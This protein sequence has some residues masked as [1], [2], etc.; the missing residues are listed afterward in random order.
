RNGV[1]FIDPDTAY[2]DSDVKIGNDTVIEGNVVIKGKTEIGSNCYIT[3]SSRIIDSKIGNN[4]TITSSTLQ[5]AQMDDNT[6]I[7]P[8]SHLRP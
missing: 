6:D 5:E 8:N 3:T 4:V 1:S 7:G 2:I